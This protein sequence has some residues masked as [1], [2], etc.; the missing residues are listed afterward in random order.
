MLLQENKL[1][2]CVKEF[3]IQKKEF[4]DQIPQIKSMFEQMIKQQDE[5]AKQQIYLFIS[6]LFNNNSK[7]NEQEKF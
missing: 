6:Q 3:E 1:Q 4:D 7:F 5:F 2:S